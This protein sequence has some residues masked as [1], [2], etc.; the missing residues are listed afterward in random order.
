M[1]ITRLLSAELLDASLGEL[2]S[3]LQI[4]FMVEP[5]WLLAHYYFAGYRCVTRDASRVVSC[6]RYCDDVQH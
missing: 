6:C 3:S 4:N 1:L 2:Q 5:G